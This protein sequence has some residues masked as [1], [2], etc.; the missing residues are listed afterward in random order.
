MISFAFLSVRNPLNEGCLTCPSVVHSEN[1][2]S[3][4]NSGDT[5][6]SVPVGR[7]DHLPGFTVR[8]SSGASFTSIATNLA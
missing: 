5:Q 1:A 8:A 4:T 6:R 7:L 2:T 3:A